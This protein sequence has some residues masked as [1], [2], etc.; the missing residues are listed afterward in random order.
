MD[1][2]DLK[3]DRAIVVGFKRSRCRTLYFS[4]FWMQKWV[5]IKEIPMSGASSI[6]IG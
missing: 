5:Q 2:I 4:T 6:Q 3:V 1:D